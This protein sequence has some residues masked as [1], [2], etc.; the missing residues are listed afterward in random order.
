MYINCV[1]LPIFCTL[2]FPIPTSFFQKLF[3]PLFVFC[4]SLFVLSP[5]PV[6]SFTHTHLSLFL[7]FSFLP[8]HFITLLAFSLLWIFIFLFDS[9]LGTNLGQG[10]G[11][12]GGERDR[13]EETGR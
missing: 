9:C 6:P 7:F 8:A 10:Q 3:T 13:Q 11:Q 5:M 12:D 4:R 1:L 2:Y